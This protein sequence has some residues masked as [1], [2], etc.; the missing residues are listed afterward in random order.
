MDRF[1][2]SVVA[3]L[4]LT[5][6]SAAWCQGAVLSLRSGPHLPLDAAAC[7]GRLSV[8]IGQ[9]TNERNYDHDH[10]EQQTCQHPP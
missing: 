8:G 4:M 5:L 7:S 9:P 6:A 2:P 3:H 1:L 10:S